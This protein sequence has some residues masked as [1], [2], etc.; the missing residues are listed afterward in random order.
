MEPKTPAPTQRFNASHVV[1]AELAHLD[2]ATRQP[3]LSM[4]DA[5][6]WRRRLLAVKCR[7]EM[8]QRQNMR[9]ERILQR[10]GYPS[11]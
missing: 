9:L 10:L 8:T 3:A 7:F 1:E 5:G 6:Y 11:D 2:W 4:L